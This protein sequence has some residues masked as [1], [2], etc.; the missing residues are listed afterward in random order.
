[1]PTPPNAVVVASPVARSTSTLHGSPR[2]PLPDLAS[3]SPRPTASSISSRG[4]GRAPGFND[5]TDSIR[6]PVC[7]TKDTAAG[8]ISCTTTAMCASADDA[9]PTAARVCTASGVNSDAHTAAIAS[10]TAAQLSARTPTT[11]TCPPHPLICAGSSTLAEARTARSPVPNVPDSRPKPAHIVAASSVEHPASVTTARTAS[12]ARS[13]SGRDPRR[14]ALSTLSTAFRYEDHKPRSRSLDSIA[15]KGTTMPSRA[16]KPLPG[17]AAMRVRSPHVAALRP[18][19]SATASASRTHSTPLEMSRGLEMSANGGALETPRYLAS[20]RSCADAR[21]RSTPPSFTV[22]CTQSPINSRAAL[23]AFSAPFADGVA[24]RGTPSC[25]A[26][27]A[28]CEVG[29]NALAAMIPVT[30]RPAHVTSSLPSTF[31]TNAMTGPSASDPHAPGSSLSHST[32]RPTPLPRT[33]DFLEPSPRPAATDA[34][35]RMGSTSLD[36][37]KG[38]PPRMAVS[39]KASLT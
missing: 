15:P 20:S 12:Q 16:L 5:F 23:A 31:Q 18:A 37:W 28:R 11:L 33:I 32:R 19:R 29:F 27:T 30:C 39:A 7:R 34:A 8:A 36:S 2:D 24:V 1:M 3:A 4:S 9:T 21:P 26:R 14:V 6:P 22:S 25:L 10:A 35:L 38:T 17:R 13:M